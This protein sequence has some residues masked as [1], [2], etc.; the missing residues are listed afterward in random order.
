MFSVG[1]VCG[2]VMVAA[3]RTVPGVS[4]GGDT[5]WEIRRIFL[6]RFRYCSV[7]GGQCSRDTVH[8]DDVLYPTTRK[9]T[10]T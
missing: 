4:S 10:H 6:N 9:P 8:P 5:L 3:F 1:T 7:L 2:F